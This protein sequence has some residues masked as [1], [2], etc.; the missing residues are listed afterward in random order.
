MTQTRMQVS[1]TGFDE[2]MRALKDFDP[3]LRK[4]TLR[5]IRRPLNAAIKQMRGMYSQPPMSGWRTVAAA[6][7]RTRGGAGWPAWSGVDRGLKAQVGR[8]RRQTRRQEWDIASIVQR[9]PAGEIYEF[10]DDARAVGWPQASQF[11]ANV[12]RNGKPGRVVY[13]VLE[14]QSADIERSVMDAVHKAEAVVNQKLGRV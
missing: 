1:M 6:N 14:G 5:E 10:A 12:R 11:I 9:S 8:T 4:Q 13:R 3:E 7:G 2:T